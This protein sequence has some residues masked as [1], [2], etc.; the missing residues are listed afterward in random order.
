VNAATLIASIAQAPLW[1]RQEAAAWLFVTRT[2][3]GILLAL[4]I[5][6]RFDLSSPGSAAVTVSII[7]LPQAGMVLEKSFYRLLGTFLGAVVTLLLLSGLVQHRDLFIVAVAAW[8]GICTAAA[9][10]FRG[11]QAYGWLLCGYTT[12]LIGF[13][14][15]GDATHAFAIAVDRVTIVSVGIVCAGVVN[16]VILPT[17]SADSLVQVVRR[18]F[19][20][21]V[22]FLDAAT[23]RGGAAT[24]AATQQQF[25]RDLA[26]LEALRAASLFEDPASRIRNTRLSA[27]I[28]SFMAASSRLQVLHRQLDALEAEG[29]DAVLAILEPTL[30]RLRAAVRVAEQVPGTARAAAPLEAQLQ[31]LLDE[32][33]DGQAPRQSASEPPRDAREPAAVGPAAAARAALR[34]TELLLREAVEHVRILASVYARLHAPRGSERGLPRFRQGVASD[35]VLA[36]VGGVRAAVVLIVM[37]TFWIATAWPSGFSA[38]LLAAVGCALFASVPNPT[39]AARQMCSGFLVGLPALLIC[40][41]W[42]LPAANG[43]GMLCLALLPFLAFGAWLMTRPGQ[44]LSGSGYFLMFLTGLDL[45]SPMRYD[46]IG[47]CNNAIGL[48][49]GIGFAALSLGVLAPADRD[50][51]RQRALRRLMCSLEFAAHARME[52]L[53][54]RFES[55]VRDLTLQA[56]ALRPVGRAV[57]DDE[58]LGFVILDIGD[59]LIRWRTSMVSQAFDPRTASRLIDATLDAVARRDARVLGQLTRELEDLQATAVMELAAVGDDTARG[60]ALAGRLAALRTLRA[61]LIEFGEVSHAA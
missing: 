53:Q 5:A 7:A 22:S 25:S 51:R 32:W 43:F 2:V 56:L 31:A 46:F 19:T 42:V 36:V 16:A 61:G 27:F 12:C 29:Q 40:Y 20:D 47:M 21:F 26:N 35:P 4:G 11:F 30:S 34:A 52:E 41:T 49:A 6:F 54:P 33:R 15:F 44:T 37:C 8:I 55:R 1:V 17:R 13:P 60:A 14:A 58:A 3:L 23:A 48:V 57:E 59:A 38:T 10:W 24:L 9:A 18:S 50:W 28:V 39:L 45:S